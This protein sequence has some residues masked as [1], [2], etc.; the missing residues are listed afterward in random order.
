MVG[1]LTLFREKLPI[2]GTN[3]QMLVVYHPEPGSP[4]ADKLTLLVS[5]ELPSLGSPSRPDIQA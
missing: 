1:E 2:T 4:D 5:S 3:G